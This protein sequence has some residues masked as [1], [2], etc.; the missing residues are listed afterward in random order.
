M[1]YLFFSTIIAALL[2]SSCKNINNQNSIDE[3]EMAL[4]P[5]E[6]EINLRVDLENFTAKLTEK[7]T[8]KILANL[9]MEFWIRRD[10]LVFTKNNNQIQLNIKVEEDTTWQLE[11]QMRTTNLPTKILEN[12]S[13][14]LEKHFVNNLKL[15]KSNGNDHWF[16]K[17]INQKDTLTFYTDNL[18]K[19]GLLN[20]EY[21][22]IM[23]RIYPNEKIFRP[24]EVIEEKE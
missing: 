17:I 20:E 12:Y 1:K 21:F 3:S 22:R 13:F 23:R 5:F 24:I 6:S 15:T 2:F 16:Y 7:D 19:M 4:K 9:S 10:E 11:Y 14:E 8:I 18:G